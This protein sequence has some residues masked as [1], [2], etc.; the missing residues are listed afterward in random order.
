MSTT[1]RIKITAILI[2]FLSLTAFGQNDVSLDPPSQGDVGK[3]FDEAVLSSESSN[4]SDESRSDTSGSSPLGNELSLGESD[5]ISV[6]FPNEEIRTVLRN[7]AD[8]YMLNIVIPE[9]LQGTTS[10]KLREVSWRQIFNVVLDPIGFTYV[11]EGNIINVISND[12]LNFEPPV[13]DIFMLNSLF[14]GLPRGVLQAMAAAV[15]VV[16]TAVDGT[17]EVVE[18]G[19]TGLLVPPNRP[20]EAAAALL[21]LAGDARLRRRCGR[22]ARERVD[23]RFDIRRMVRRLDRIYLSLLETEL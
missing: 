4:E 14:E 22:L 19:R 12:T 9:S 5:M 7:V 21:E 10:I 13:T 15:P 8:L 11:E 17:P 16:A 1:I 23:A 2:G 6:D 3:Q 20:E 18:H